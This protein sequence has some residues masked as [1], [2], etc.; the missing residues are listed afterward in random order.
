[1]HLMYEID[2]FG[3]S[4]S[5]CAGT[6]L[7]IS[8][9]TASGFDTGNPPSYAIDNNFGTRWANSFNWFMDSRRSQDQQKAF[10]V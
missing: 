2:V 4:S 9:V 6:N 1:M 10:A 8:G 5:S 7:P 3:S